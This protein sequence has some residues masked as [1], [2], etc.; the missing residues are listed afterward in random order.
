MRSIFVI[1]RDM[2]HRELSHIRTMLV[3]LVDSGVQTTLA[4]PEDMCHAQEALPGVT[5]LGYRDRGSPWTRSLRGKDLVARLGTIEPEKTVVHGI[6]GKAHMMAA[7]LS[8]QIG[9]PVLLEVHSRESI[10][11]A[12]GIAK[13]RSGDCLL[14]A[15]SPQLARATT[16]A[17][18]AP[19][20]VRELPWGVMKNDNADTK[21]QSPT[22]GVVVTGSGNDNANWESVLRALAQ[23]ASR[24]E[25]F[26]VLANAEAASVAGVG[27]LVRSLGLSPLFSRVPKLESDRQ[28]VLLADIM[29]CPDAEG[30]HRSIVF[31]AMAA[32][33]A[34]VAAEDSDIPA[35]CDPKVVRVASGDVSEWTSAI[36][37][38]IENAGLR[39]ELGQRAMAYVAEHHRPSRYVA[40]LVD[41]YGWML[42]ND[43]IPMTGELS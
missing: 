11:R 17:G 36:E 9:S 32:G 4:L 29:V 5:V 31:D 26:V 42:G 8:H 1:D 12:V 20:S 28:V 3:G 37:D 15:P 27:G 38:L 41:A 19:A 33:M 18:A 6:G 13:E 35:L 23:I 7:E 43:S 40:G 24:R 34:I 21:S 22:T 30:E 10:L 25:D 2:A 14:L 16:A 39:R